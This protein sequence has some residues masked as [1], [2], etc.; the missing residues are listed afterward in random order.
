MTDVCVVD[1][2]TSILGSGEGAYGKASPFE[3]VNKMVSIGVLTDEDYEYD[4]YSE[5]SDS[6]MYTCNTIL[7]Q[8]S[9]WVGHNIK[10]DLHY[11][12][13]TIGEDAW[14][15]WVKNGCVFDTMIAEYIISGQTNTTPSLDELTI[16]YRG[17][18]FVKDSKIKEYWNQGIDTTDIP[19]NE[20]LDYMKADVY[21][22]HHI[23]LKQMEVLKNLDLMTV[24]NVQCN[25]TLALQEM[26]WNGFTYKVEE[27]ASVEK[28]LKMSVD[29][30]YKSLC[31]MAEGLV[32]TSKADIFKNIFN[33]GSPLQVQALLFGG[34]ISYSTK[35]PMRD[36]DG[37]VL[38]FSAK[39]K[40]AGQIRTKKV[41]DDLRLSST[42]HAAHTF[43]LDG[44]SDDRT[45]KIV[46]SRSED[47]NSNLHAFCAGILEYRKVYKEWSTY[48]AKFTKLANLCDGYIHGE[49]NQTVAIT[50]RLS[51]SK[52]NMQNITGKD[53]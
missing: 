42:T 22:T 52:P 38:R 9:V 20:L 4:Y 45:L 1:C 43:D 19:K 26:E 39:A 25:Y 14:F 31:S 51:S 27:A 13:M 16:K 6:E 23:Y 36:D 32:S 35:I 40:K 41:D 47:S 10:F 5:L 24:F 53:T 11:I 12:R 44:S 28:Q 21:N 34:S 17:E 48:V 7:A 50:G 8:S 2:E 37:N 49:F 46:S 30:Q 33:P 29:T 15:E 18:E 3:G